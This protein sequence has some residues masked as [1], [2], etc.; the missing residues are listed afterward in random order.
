MKTAGI[1]AVILKG[2]AVARHYPTP[3]LRV[4]G[5]IDCLVSAADYDRAEAILLEA[6]FLRE[7]EPD[8]RHAAY[9]RGKHVVELHRAVAG[10][11]DGEMGACV[12]A[13]LSD[14][15]ETAVMAEWNG[16]SIPV[17]DPF[18]QALILLLH[19]QQHMREGGLGLRQ[20][21]DYTFFVKKEWDA[22]LTPRL[23]PALKSCGLY[24]FAET[25][26]LAA[27]RHLGLSPQKN[28]FSEGDPYLA[29]ALFADFLAGGNFGRGNAAY[30]GSAVVTLRRREGKSAKS[31][32][33]KCSSF[34]LLSAR[35]HL[36]Q[37]LSLISIHVSDMS[38]AWNICVIER[39]SNGSLNSFA[40]L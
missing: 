3:E 31:F 19:M 7:A 18:H 40:A 11:P 36:K 13:L 21:M 22:S 28:P 35:T 15:L 29:D 37:Y 33:R 26:T 17:P 30:A 39:I 12:K 2:D 8:E 24:R 10:I 1:P 14:T 34:V 6:K 5:D 32:S 16:E 9:R 27:V 38:R 4:A 23:I 25:L 20:M